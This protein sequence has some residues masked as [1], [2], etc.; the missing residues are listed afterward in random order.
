MAER[1]DY[2]ALYSAT[3]LFSVTSFVK[4]AFGLTRG[5][6]LPPRSVF[7]LTPNSE[8]WQYPKSF[9]TSEFLAYLNKKSSNDA[10]YR[11][12][13]DRKLS[14][15]AVPFRVKQCH[16]RLAQPAKT[17]LISASGLSSEHSKRPLPSSPEL[18]KEGE[19]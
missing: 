1:G 18:E 8:P 14:F 19:A 13:P 10:Q 9:A 6:L 11:R 5:S 16:P 15:W 3:L 2:I 12:Q 17:V 7:S 4:P